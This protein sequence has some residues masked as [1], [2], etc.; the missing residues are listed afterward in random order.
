[1]AFR[2]L[3]GVGG[4]SFLPTSAGIVSDLFPEHRERAI[5]LFTSIFPIGGILG[6][7]LGGWIVSQYSWRYIFYI[8][9]P[10]GITLIV[11]IMILLEDSKVPSRRHIDFKGASLFFGAIIFL[12]LSLNVI[13][14]NFSVFFLFVAIICS[15]FS[16]FFIY[17]F[18]RQERKESNPI[19]D[20]ALL[21]S[22]PFLA[23]NLY[24]MMVGVGLGTFAFI[25]LY[26]TSVYKLSTLLSGMILTPQ[27]LA[28]IPAAAITSFSLKRWGYRTPMIVGL[29]I[30]SLSIIL[31]GGPGF[32]LLRMIDIK[33]GAAS[34]LAFL[35]MIAGVGM[36]ICLPASNNACI[37]LMPDRVATISGLRGMLTTVILHLTSTPA[38]GFRI[39]FPCFGVILL[40]AIPLVFLMPSG[41]IGMMAPKS[42]E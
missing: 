2:F 26:A 32:W 29:S 4:A 17:L 5:G 33:L 6:P 16:L 31:L 3:Q 14:E 40:S 39:V 24:N 23:A 42:I 9:L 20:V 37:E 38:N 36:G 19:L 8:N 13:A 15:F 10:I 18:F 1:V 25:P 41:K 35:V 28:V 7:N 22:R 34:I 27:S 12:I 30:M 21:R 11:L